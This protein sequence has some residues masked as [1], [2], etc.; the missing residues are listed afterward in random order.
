ME[1]Q[2]YPIETPVPATPPPHYLRPVFMG[3]D[4]IRAGWS[5]LL[6]VAIFIALEIATAAIFHLF[7][8]THPTAKALQS[9]GTALVQ[10]GIQA[11]L[12]LIATA[13]MARIEGRQANAYGYSGQARLIRF[14]GGI[15]CGFAAIS[16]LVGML[17]EVGLLDLGRRTLHGGL[18]WEYAA[19]WGAV[20][21]CVAVFEESLL[22][23][24]LQFTLARG[25]GFWWGAVLLSFFFGFAHGHNPGESPVGLFSAGAIGLVFCLSLWYTGSLWWALGFHAA[26]DWGESYFYGTADSGLIAK[27]HLFTEHPKGTLLWSGGPTGPEGSLLIFPLVAVI[28][29]LMW[30]W[31][32]RGRARDQFPSVE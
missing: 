30:L 19:A 7:T 9:P 18:I 21:L 20:F 11:L 8:Q 1:E 31:W 27:G 22:R 14:A 15:L 13:I 4:G 5:V 24:Y 2:Q 29:L 10:E 32:G 23:G 28:A 16:A 12:V 25:L 3:K 26:W 17:S 6:F